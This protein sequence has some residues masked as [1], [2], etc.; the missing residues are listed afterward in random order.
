MVISLK[1]QWLFVAYHDDMAFP[2]YASPDRI[3]L[4]V[5]RKYKVSKALKWYYSGAS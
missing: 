5:M 1:W 2:D 3:A 4:R